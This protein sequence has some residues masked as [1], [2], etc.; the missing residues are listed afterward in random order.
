MEKTIINKLNSYDTQFYD[1]KLI[2]AAR[3]QYLKLNSENCKASK[4]S[5]QLPPWP[6]NGEI[7][8][9]PNWLNTQYCDFSNIHLGQI[10][11]YYDKKLAKPFIQELFSS[12]HCATSPQHDAPHSA[13]RS[14]AHEGEKVDFASQAGAASPHRAPVKYKKVS[15]IDPM[16]TKKPHFCLVR[17][18]ETDSNMI[19]DINFENYHRNDLLSHQLWKRNQNYYFPKNQ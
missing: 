8:N 12:P 13:A 10:N 6:L 2:N 9:Y 1:P 16:G 15:Y 5:L 7:I 11:Y 3:G 19:S 18:F 17:P 4:D 14:A